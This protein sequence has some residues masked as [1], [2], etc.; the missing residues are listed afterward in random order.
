MR[1][2]V[3]GQLLNPV[4][5]LNWQGKM[6]AGKSFTR[7]VVL[8][9]QCP[10]KIPV[11]LYNRSSE[12]QLRGFLSVFD[13]NSFLCFGYKHTLFEKTGAANAFGTDRLL[14][15]DGRPAT[16]CGFR[17]AEIACKQNPGHTVSQSRSLNT[18]TLPRLA[19]VARISC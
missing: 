12:R 6:P 18:F 7:F 2:G 15:I 5:P 13:F 11:V 1:I 17:P 16:Y 19:R 9:Q 10:V 8:D 14:A 3:S 4:W